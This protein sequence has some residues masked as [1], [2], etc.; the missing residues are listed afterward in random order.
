MITRPKTRLT[1]TEPS[2][3]ACVAFVTTAPQPAKTSAN[4]AIASAT[5]RRSRPGR[6]GIDA[7]E[8]HADDRE[9]S[10]QAVEREVADVVFGDSEQVLRCAVSG[11]L[12]R[13]GDGGQQLAQ[14]RPHRVR[15]LRM[16]LDRL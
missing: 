5:E 14:R 3:S 13:L 15:L 12:E 7:L 8:R 6:S 11:R 10:R 1:P 2:A 16:R 9:P 4:A